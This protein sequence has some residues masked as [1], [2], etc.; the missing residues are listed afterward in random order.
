MAQEAEGIER[1]VGFE[2]A[3]VGRVDQREF[4]AGVICDGETG[5]GDAILEACGGTG[6]LEWLEPHGGEE[7]LIDPEGLP[8]STRYGDVTEVRRVEAASEEGNA[9]AAGLY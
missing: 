3:G 7:N 5:H 4:K 6:R 9:L 2:T 8:G 1:V